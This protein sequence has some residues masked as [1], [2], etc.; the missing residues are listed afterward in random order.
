MHVDKVDERTRKVTIKLLTLLG[1]VY[2]D[3]KQN[4]YDHIRHTRKGAQQFKYHHA[5]RVW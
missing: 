5:E 2:S 1:A 3:Q 4:E